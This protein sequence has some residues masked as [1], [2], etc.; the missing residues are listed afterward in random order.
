MYNLTN[1]TSLEENNEILNSVIFVV[2]LFGCVICCGF[3]CL[4]LEGDPDYRKIGCLCKPI[5][6]WCLVLQNLYFKICNIKIPKIN[7]NWNWYYKIFGVKIPKAE[8][9]SEINPPEIIKVEFNNNIISFVPTNANYASV[10]YS[11]RNK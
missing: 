6:F 8:R 11:P 2:C 4:F 1:S 7:C 10:I 5:I 3:P 9:C